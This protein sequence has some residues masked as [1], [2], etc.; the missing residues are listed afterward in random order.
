M[1]ATILPKSY[2]LLIADP[3]LRIIPIT[4]P[5]LPIPIRIVY[6]EE[7]FS[8]PTINAFIS[9]LKEDYLK[10]ESFNFN[11]YEAFNFNSN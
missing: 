1:T 2:L 5:P 9:H 8:D 4:N 6:R 3:E 7:S 11:R 10:L